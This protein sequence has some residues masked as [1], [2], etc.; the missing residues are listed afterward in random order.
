VEELRLLSQVD[1]VKTLRELITAG[2]SDATHNAKLVYAFFALKLISRRELTSKSI[3]KI[4][5]KTAGSE[6]GKG[7]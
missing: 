5:W 6:F 4:Q 2:P 1:G 3:K 7:G